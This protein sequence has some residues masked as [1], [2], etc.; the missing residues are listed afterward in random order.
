MYGVVAL[1]QQILQSPKRCGNIRLVTI[2]GPAGSGKTTL[3]KAV[4]QHTASSAVIPMDGLY[5][6]WTD[7]LAPELWDRIYQLIL[8]PLSQGRAA[9]YNAFNWVT[10]AFD[11]AVEIEPTEVIILEGV[12]ASH[13][14][15][16]AFSSLNIWISAPEEVLL[17]RVLE[18]DGIHIREE[19]L[20]WQLA[21]REYFTQFDIE[22]EAD[23]HLTGR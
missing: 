6:G 19:M 21:E 1:S 16:K 11:T 3:A 17:N 20:A 23:I 7:A 22:A 12:G 9:Q 15:V 5:N 13:P 18:R 8:Q 10:N 2:D 14:S 4:H